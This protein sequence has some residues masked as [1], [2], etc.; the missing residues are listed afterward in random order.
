MFFDVA[1]I[2]IG[3]HEI[4]EQSASDIADLFRE[5]IGGGVRWMFRVGAERSQFNVFVGVLVGSCLI[6]LGGTSSDFFTGLCIGIMINMIT[7]QPKYF[8]QQEKD[9]Y[10][11]LLMM[12]G[13][14]KDEAK[15]ALEEQKPQIMEMLIECIEGKVKTAQ[16]K[17]VEEEKKKMVG[18]F[19]KKLQLS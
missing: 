6:F 4:T 12:M 3:L 8:E 13:Y 18:S 1:G 11:R 2:M 9:Q 19:S 16:N 14:E 17:V 7:T 15:R 5:W 10:L